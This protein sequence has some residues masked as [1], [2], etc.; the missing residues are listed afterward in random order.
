MYNL[1]LDRPI[2]KTKNNTH[3]FKSIAVDEIIINFQ[4][5]NHAL[6]SKCLI[7]R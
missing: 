4:I 3:R 6:M 1:M 5:D 7:R 2:D